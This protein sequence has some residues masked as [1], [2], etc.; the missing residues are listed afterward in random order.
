MKA[1]VHIIKFHVQKESENYLF[2]VKVV[3]C[4]TNEETLAFLLVSLRGV[5]TDITL[6]ESSWFEERVSCVCCF[7]CFHGS[8]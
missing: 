6:V 8:K 4:S 5:F 1:L 3:S 7:T 2:I